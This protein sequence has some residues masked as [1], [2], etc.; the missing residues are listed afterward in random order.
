M[1]DLKIKNRFSFPP[2]PVYGNF[3][4]KLGAYL[5]FLKI[6]VSEEEALKTAY[7]EWKFP[8]PTKG[9]LMGIEIEIEKMNYF[10][11]FV[12]MPDNQV[13]PLFYQKGDGSL[14]DGGIELISL[15]QL[16]KLSGIFTTYCV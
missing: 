7:S 3:K 8:I 13:V 6:G 11:D 2:I 14:R 12:R 10:N 4:D 9:D 1:L 16:V 15:A 5:Q